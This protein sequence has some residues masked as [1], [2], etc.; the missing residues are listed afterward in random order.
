MKSKK[1]TAILLSMAMVLSATGIP[2]MGATGNSTRR[3]MEQKAS[4]RTASDSDAEIAT[5]S[6][7]TYVSNEDELRDALEKD[8][9]ILLETDIEVT[10][11]LVVKGQRTVQF[12]G[13]GNKI[14]TGENREMGRMMWIDP[15]ASVTLGNI[16]FDATGMD[17]ASSE[18]PKQDYYAIMAAAGSTLSI[19][20]GTRIVSNDSEM[21]DNVRKGGVYLR[22]TGI[23]NGG[24]ISGF[25]MGGLTAGS[26]A[27]FYFN[28]GWIT[29]IGNHVSSNEGGGALNIRGSVIMNGGAISGNLTGVLNR[30]EFI[31]RGGE[32]VSNQ[33]GIVN[34]NK[35]IMS[36]QTFTPSVVLAGGSVMENEYYAIYNCA[37][38]TVLINGGHIGGQLVASS[39]IRAASAA[40]NRKYVVGNTKGSTLR[41]EDGSIESKA[42]H[43]IA[44]FNDETSKLQMTGG[45]VA[46]HGQ[47]SVAIQNENAAEGAAVIS[48]G[49]IVSEGAGSKAL[50]NTG[51]ITVSGEV[52]VEAE[53]QFL[54]EVKQSGSGAITPD[55]LIADSGQKILFKIK[56]DSG[57]R[58]SDVKVDGVSVGAVSGYEL[59]A[60]RKHTLEAIF[61]KRTS[62]GGSSSGG[63]SDREEGDSGNS[64]KAGKTDSIPETAGTWRQDNGQWKFA[65]NDGSFY[66][67]TWIYK[68]HNWYWMNGSGN[69]ADGW[70]L[71][72]DQW[73]YLAPGSGEMKTGWVQIGDTW[74]Y[75]QENGAL[76]VNTTTPD[77]YPVD[78]NGAWVR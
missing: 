28:D 77:G 44:I 23:M 42:D 75:L 48:G 16:V 33:S 74:Y 25:Y 19:E 41:F 3:Q 45:T 70:N 55:S 40:N 14:Y 18:D 26:E 43:E 59:T 7:A 4:V 31:M 57:H 52:E 71:I 21:P 49:S 73:Y 10:K 5:P 35:D 34:N 78:E 62:S 53:D 65:A 17:L 13:G 61:E 30:G 2:T 1:M 66:Q 76:A 32:I 51:S 69:M 20:A 36:G 56:A 11:P 68:N 27:K 46:V 8:G 39:K 24:E 22:G 38:G 12:D 37:G 64:A 9:L 72:G 15:G 50:E 47:Q 60:D 54:I 63:S 67:N 6:N 29:E 58:I